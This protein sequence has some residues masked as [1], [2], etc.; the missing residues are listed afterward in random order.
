[1]KNRLSAVLD[2]VPFSANVIADIG[3]DHG[4][5]VRE[6]R[7][8]LPYARVIASDI[9]PNPL[10]IAKQNLQKWEIQGVEFILSD[11]F[12]KLPDEVDTAI[13]AGMGGETIAEILEA[14]PLYKKKR[15][16]VVAQPMSKHDRMLKRFAADGWNIA[17]E[18]TVCEGKRNYYLCAVKQV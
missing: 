16:T 13:I 12:K 8:R 15:L 6:L 1:M 5:A 10:E 18:K 11:G 17:A 7:R 4:I 9:N 3:V 2:F 14:C